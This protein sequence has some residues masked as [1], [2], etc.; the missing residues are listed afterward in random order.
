MTPWFPIEHLAGCR[1]EGRDAVAFCQ[2]QF[3][4]DVAQL[5]ND[6]W[7]QTAWC[8]RKGRVRFISLAKTDQGDVELILPRAQT[9]LLQDLALFTIG[10]KVNIQPPSTVLGSY[11]REE[12]APIANDEAARHLLLASDSTP[13]SKPAD[14]N[15]LKRWQ[16]DDLRLPL[17]WLD[18]DSQDKFLPQALALEEND[19]LSYR[20]GCYPGQEIVARVHYL[21][22]APE[23]LIGL[24]IEGDAE[25]DMPSLRRA[26]GKTASGKPITIV[27]E[28]HAGAT[29]L[30]LAVVPDDA[31]VGDRI[32]LSGPDF[33]G[34]AEMAAP[35]TLC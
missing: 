16:L 32:A 3:T 12:G 31:K 2:S 28:A 19:G 20:K 10:R 34:E 5:G 33:S 7:R 13:D 1:I 21:G 25:Q 15:T 11:G 14:T 4:S 27:A 30:A 9:A 8:N 6:C 29:R 22:R 18:E 24:R 23:R 35:Q 17:P 26:S